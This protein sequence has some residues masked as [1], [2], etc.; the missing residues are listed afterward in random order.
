LMEM[1]KLES[2]KK[3]K[4]KYNHELYTKIKRRV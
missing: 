2:L 1:L 4:N 3:L